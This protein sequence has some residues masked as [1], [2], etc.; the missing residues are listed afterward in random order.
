MAI[1]FTASL[2]PISNNRV[3][4]GQVDAIDPLAIG[5]IPY[6]FVGVG[7]SR[8]Y[9]MGHEIGHLF[10]CYHDDDFSA[11]KLFNKHAFGSFFCVYYTLDFL[12]VDTNSR[13]YAIP[14]TNFKTIV[15]YVLYCIRNC[16]PTNLL[17]YIL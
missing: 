4:C 15:G 16:V 5:R 9:I 1:F 6:A 2:V 17:I 10:G 13:A 7:C 3:T 11:S 12:I 14:N 8:P